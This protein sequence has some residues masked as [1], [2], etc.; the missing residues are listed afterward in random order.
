MAIDET[1]IW[2]KDGVIYQ[3][4][5]LS[6]MDSD[7]NGSG[8]LNGIRSR[9]DYLQWLGAD[10]LWLSPI[11]RSPMID[12]GYD[13]AD[14]T[15]INPLFGTMEDF[16]RFLAE[17][18]GRGMKIILDFVPNH[19]SDEHPWFRESRSSR[20]NPR[21]DWYFW[22]DP[23]P[24][25]GPPNNW[26]I[27]HDGSAW[28]FDPATEQYYYHAFHREQPD[29]NWRNPRVR[30]ALADVMRFWLDKG[31]D[32]FRVDVMWHLMKDRYF[33]NNPPNPGFREG[34]PSHERFVAVYSANHPEVH[35]AVAFLRRV[36]DDYSDRALM[37]ELY[38]STSEV[39]GYYGAGGKG[40][41]LPS[42][43]LLILQDWAAPGI[44]LG[45]NQY[46]ALLPSTAWPNWTIGNHDW[47][48]A[49][50]RLGPSQARVGALLQM[51]LRGTPTIYYGEEI[52]MR[53]APVPP[54]RAR[55]HSGQQKDK[56]RTPMQ[57]NAERNAGFTTGEPWLPVS[58]DFRRVN[59]ESERNDPGSMLTLYHRLIEFRRTERVIRDGLFRP[60]GIEGSRFAFLRE[61]VQAGRRFLVAVNLGP[62][63]GP[64]TGTDFAGI[65]GTVRISTIPG[66]EN[67]KIGNGVDLLG[68]EGIV[69]ELRS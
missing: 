38:L 37:G 14:Y 48:R 69:A 1:R 36:M 6:F 15:E 51:T 57:W 8:D 59:V 27:D 50:T 63:P 5:P 18:H 40:A 34:M 46:E 11:N 24:G 39:I 23:G 19:T 3:V 2:W 47:S 42:N 25:G 29:L 32:G 43:F 55:D 10:I 20:D 58:P 68:D 67:R 28:E 22:R 30:E 26:L 60:L 17:V 4:Y 41:H 35:D 66:R 33:R 64:I 9:L 12:F 44:Y 62:D 21:R 31:V 61:D 45:I 49:A 16:E 56:Q 65:E 13:V 54:E 7:G 52:G 53:D